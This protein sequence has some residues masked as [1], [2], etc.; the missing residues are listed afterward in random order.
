VDTN[1]RLKL[2]FRRV[3]DEITNQPASGRALVPNLFE[4][5]LVLTDYEA[6]IDDLSAAISGAGW[7]PGPIEICPA[8]KTGGLVRPGTR[9]GVADRVVYTAAVGACL[10]RIENVTRWSQKTVDFGTWLKPQ[11]L[12][13][14][15]WLASPFAGWN[16]WRERSLTLLAQKQTEWV[17]VADVAGFFENVS[18][19]RLISELQRLGC[20]K[21]VV[22][23]LSLCLNHWAQ[24]DGRGLPQG[25]LASD[26]LAKLYLEG[27]DRALKSDG[28][29]HVRY[30]DD[31]RI[32]CRSEREAK[33]ALI[34]MTELLR[35]RG[36]TVQ[37]AKTRIRRSDGLE[38]EFDG[39]FPVIR[40]L[41]RAYIERLRVGGLMAADPSLP[42]SVIDD[43]IRKN[44]S[45]VDPKVIRQAFEQHIAG[46]SSPNRSVLHYV[47]RRMATNGDTTAVDCC[48]EMLFRAPEESGEVLRYFSGLGAGPALQKHAVKALA[49]ND[50]DMYA[51]QRHQ[52]LAWFWRDTTRIQ[53][54]TLRAVRKL[55]F[56][57][58]APGYVRAVARALLG[59][60]GDH[61]DLDNL[62]AH[63]KKASDPLERAQLLCCLERLELSRRNSLLQRVRSEQPWV[64]RAAELVKQAK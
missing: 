38:A 25:V 8:P 61:A 2:A 40:D 59:R 42:I 31:I 21:D 62:A 39:A 6:W 1:L 10:K 7:A 15:E 20:P 19:Q 13:R 58:E 11:N 57:A 16:A 53:K 18:I 14:R 17:V 45:K 52:I 48:A 47:L 43:F 33:R 26:V 54:P 5:E 63:F 44:P 55:A 27:F 22:Q 49:S 41:N 51:Y 56:D 34:R 24:A 9:L 35:E 4:L 28:Y 30:T 50:L 60:F 46:N 37:S 3:Q 23:L 36:L 29:R 64:N 12:N 32:F